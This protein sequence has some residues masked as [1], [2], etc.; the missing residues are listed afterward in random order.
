MHGVSL[1][2]G[3]SAAKRMPGDPVRD[4]TEDW[5][6]HGCPVGGVS[7]SCGAAFELKPTFAD[8]RARHWRQAGDQSRAISLRQAWARFNARTFSETVGPDLSSL[9]KST[10]ALVTAS[11]STMPMVPQ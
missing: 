7:C 1:D 2:I 3:I 8:D 11:F 4:H 10:M 9:P 6:T 5:V